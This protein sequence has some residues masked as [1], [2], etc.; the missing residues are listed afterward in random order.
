MRNIIFWIPT[1]IYIT[2]N[3]KHDASGKMNKT[4]RLFKNLDKLGMVKHYKDMELYNTEQSVWKLDIDK[5]KEVRS[6]VV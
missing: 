3:I 2:T 1:P 4:H 6:D 5:Y